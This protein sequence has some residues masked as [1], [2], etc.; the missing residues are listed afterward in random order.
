MGC[1][2]S[3]TPSLQEIDLDALRGK[4]AHER[5]RR[6]RKEGGEQYGRSTD[7]DTYE[8]DPHMPVIPR[9]PSP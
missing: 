4:Y 9:A 6:I 7:D 5:D 1:E 8:A 2:P 3:K